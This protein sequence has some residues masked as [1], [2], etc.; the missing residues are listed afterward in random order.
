[1]QVHDAQGHVHMVQG[2]RKEQD[3]EQ[4]QEH[5]DHDDH[6]VHG[7]QEQDH[8]GN[9]DHQI[10]QNHLRVPQIQDDEGQVHV[11]HGGAELELEGEV[12][13]APEELGHHEA[14]V[15]HDWAPGGCGAKRKGQDGGSQTLEGGLHVDRGHDGGL[16]LAEVHDK[17]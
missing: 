15:S 14:L 10:R 2:A 13:L 4:V 16:E 3:G 9:R 7:V 1:M 5:R 6:K 17:D 12:H 8:D 11:R